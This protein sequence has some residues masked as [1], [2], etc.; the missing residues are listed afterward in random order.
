MVKKSVI[1]RQQ[2]L[3][4]AQKYLMY[5]KHSGAFCFILFYKMFLLRRSSWCKWPEV[6]A[7]RVWMCYCEYIYILH[8]IKT[9]VYTALIKY[10]IL[11]NFRNRNLVC[12]L[13]Y[14]L[15]M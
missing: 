13:N 10:L 1:W 5:T 6:M 14:Y 15:L 7:I 12:E 2:I 8:L 4:I 3:K 11:G 9:Q